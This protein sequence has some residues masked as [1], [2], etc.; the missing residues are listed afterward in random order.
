MLLQLLTQH[1]EAIAPILRG[2]PAWVWGLLA[3]LLALGATQLRD[4]TVGLGRVSALPLSMTLFS[5]WG[6]LSSFGSSAAFASVI[7]TWLLA[8]AATFAL[9]APGRSNASF[10]A[11]SRTYALPGS[12]VPLLLIAGIFLVKYYVGVELAMAPRLVQDS[13]YALAVAG[14]YGAFSGVFLGRSFR[15]W[16][17]ALHRVAPAPLA[18]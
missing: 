11:A 8:A 3:G 7:A 4:R 13:H 16:R 6:T 14:V 9:L 10:D 1:P 18:A 2:T 17:L 5:L 15:L 12:V